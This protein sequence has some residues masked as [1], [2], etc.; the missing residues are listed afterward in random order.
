MRAGLEKIIPELSISKV[1]VGDHHFAEHD[2]FLVIQPQNE[3]ILFTDFGTEG[4]NN[5]LTICRSTTQMIIIVT[6]A[7]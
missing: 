6:R 3:P 2:F 4:I 5:S 1:V 7:N